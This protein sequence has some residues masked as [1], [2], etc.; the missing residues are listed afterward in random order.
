[1]SSSGAIL[2]NYYSFQRREENSFSSIL[3]DIR[4]Q[5]YQA[6]SILFPMKINRQLGKLSFSLGLVPR[7]RI[8]T[9]ITVETF[10]RTIFSGSSI[11]DYN[12]YQ[13]KVGEEY[14]IPPSSGGIAELEHRIDLQ[15]LIGVNY[16]VNG[17]FSI[18]AEFRNLVL[19]NKLMWIEREI[20]N[21]NSGTISLG[22]NWR[23][24]K[25]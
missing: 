10:T 7:I 20:G 12:R 22:L 21:P 6:H 25:K 16:P 18:H 5:N 4:N 9:K 19:E 3:F 2:W 24:L 11:F 1:M 17:D 14:P 13:F 8:Q 23:I 15:Y